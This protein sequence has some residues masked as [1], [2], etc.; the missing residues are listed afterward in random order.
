VTI[1]LPN[2]DCVPTF[3][4]RGLTL[5]CTTKGASHVA[6][7]IRVRLR[8]GS[9]QVRVTVDAAGHV[10]AQTRTLRVR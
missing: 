8:K 5:V 6:T 10:G 3:G 1:T 4:K 9:Y 2:V 7:L